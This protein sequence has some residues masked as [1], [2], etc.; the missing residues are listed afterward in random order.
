MAAAN[1]ARPI[2][3]KKVKKIAGGHHGGAWKVAYADFVTAMMAFFLLLWLL[4]ATTEEQRNGIAN[5]FAPAAPTASPSGSGG[6]GGGQ[7]I[8]Q[9]G[10]NNAGGQPVV[11]MALAP[12][13]PAESGEE[14]TGEQNT[15]QASSGENSSAVATP[16]PGDANALSDEQLQMEMAKREQARFEAAAQQIRQA[17]QDMPELAAISNQIAVDV[18]PE[19]MRIQLVD[20]ERS[21]MF[22]S[23][24]AVMSGATR[25]LMDKVAAIVNRLPNRISIAGHTDSSPY[26]T[27]AGYSNWELSA[28]RANATRRELL[29]AGVPSNRIYQVT[30]KADSEPLLPDSPRDPSNRRISIVLLR[31]APVAPPAPA[32]ETGP[33]PGVGA[34]PPVP[35]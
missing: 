23:G 24:K 28:D 1:D 35:R 6:V 21:S 30:G 26:R 10:S 11:V 7:S 13:T 22:Q 34:A 27:D 31:E 3:V 29:S 9:E 18:T 33:A 5:Y 8:S 17:I 15:G 14:A 19:G 16:A 12:E 4:N 20:N 2:I 32:Q 25:A